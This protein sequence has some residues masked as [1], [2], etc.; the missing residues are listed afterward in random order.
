MILQRLFRQLSASYGLDLRALAIFRMGIAIITICDLLNRSQSFL[1]FH[2]DLG[3][4]PRAVAIDYYNSPW[5]W[6]IHFFG[7]NGFF[8]GLLFLLTFLLALQFLIGYKTK[9]VAIALWLLLTSLQNLNPLILHGGDVLWR[10][11]LFWALFLPLGKVWSIDS[12]GQEEKSGDYHFSLGSLAFMGQIAIMYF[13]NG[14]LKTS[15]EWV[16]EGTALYYVLHLDHF[17]TSLGKWL[18]QFEQL[19]KVLTFSV[20][21]LEKFAVLLFFMPVFSYFFRTMGVIFLVLFHLA[22]ALTMHL[23]LF[24]WVAIIALLTLLPQ[25]IWNKLSISY[26]AKK[27]TEMLTPIILILKERLFTHQFFNYPKKVESKESWIDSLFVNLL[28]LLLMLH[29]IFW[30]L[31][32]LPKKHPLHNNFPFGKQ[33]VDSLRLDQNWNMFAPKPFTGDGWYVIAGKLRGG[34]A[35]N[36]LLGNVEISYEKPKNVFS[37]YG[38]QREAKYMIS[39]WEDYNSSYR[40]YYGRY[41][42]NSWNKYY[43]EDDVLETF[44]IIFMHEET[45]P[46]N[47]EAKPVKVLLW[48]HHCF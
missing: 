43:K 7:G 15:S 26:L 8:Q 45:L 41:L 19:C 23:G 4:F 21:Y 27:L 37:L 36:V 33:I 16:S 30:N 22:T 28:A 35:V 47:K 10:L 11:M 31:D 2:T 32:T 48:S 25:P 44:D 12:I 13:M 3:V 9:F 24:P 20:L 38:T 18:G 29:V 5:I 1:K 6:S 40:L 46:N 39:L 14:T 17:T 34:Q 42:C